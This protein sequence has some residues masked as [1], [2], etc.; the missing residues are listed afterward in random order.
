MMI[1]A[2]K[3]SR[4]KSL[5]VDEIVRLHVYLV[6]LPLLSGLQKMIGD[7]EVVQTNVSKSTDVVRCTFN[8]W[9]YHCSADRRG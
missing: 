4:E 1:G 3:V 6:A 8:S 2:L 9:H 5:H 7:I